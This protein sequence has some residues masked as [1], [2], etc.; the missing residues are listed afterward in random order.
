ME[1]AT[2]A[3]HDHSEVLHLSGHPLALVGQPGIR[4]SLTRYLRLEVGLSRV[5]LPQQGKFLL[6]STNQGMHRSRLRK[7]SAVTIVRIEGHRLT[8]CA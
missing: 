2:E 6:L 5:L 8:L 3:G 1:C 4:L 7:Q